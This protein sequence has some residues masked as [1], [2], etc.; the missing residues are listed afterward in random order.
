MTYNQMNVGRS[1]WMSIHQ[2][3][4][5]TSRAVERDWIWSWSEAVKAVFA[6]IVSEKLSTQI[7]FDLFVI[8]LFIEPW[9]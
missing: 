9:L 4:N 1:I 2:L 7:M 5:F 6:F 8:L 3:Q